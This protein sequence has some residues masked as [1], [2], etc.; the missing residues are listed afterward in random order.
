MI[1]RS[2]PL[3][4][5]IL[6]LRLESMALLIAALAFYGL[7]GGSWALFTLLFLVPDLSALGYLVGETAGTACYNAAHT[8]ILPFA[9]IALGALGGHP[10]VL[11]LA[12]IW[13]AH[14]GWDRLIGYGL[15]E[16]G[17]AR[18]THR[19]GGGIT[20]RRQDTLAGA[21]AT[22]DYPA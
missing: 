7:R 2:N 15:K 10:L 6:I 11:L 19:D 5:P 8:T 21:I 16:V 9:L 17:A 14:I 1:V 13:L 12:T 22:P 4:R 20:R 3:I 18:R